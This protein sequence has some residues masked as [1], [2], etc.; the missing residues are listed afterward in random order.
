ML[1]IIIII[2]PCIRRNASNPPDTNCVSLSVRKEN[3]TPNRVNIEMALM[4]LTLVVDFKME[5]TVMVY[6]HQ[7][8]LSIG[9]GSK[10]IRCS[11]ARE[12]LAA[13]HGTLVVVR[14]NEKSPDSHDSPFITA[15]R[16]YP[17]L[18]TRLYCKVLVFTMVLVIRFNNALM[19]LMRQPHNLVP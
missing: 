12:H 9:Q 8:A 3:G 5:S 7:N 18:A 13:E 11:L 16:L 17:C 14:H 4:I 2:S 6:K 15:Q 1:Y 19:Q 10:K